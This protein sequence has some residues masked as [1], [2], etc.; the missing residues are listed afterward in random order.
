MAPSAGIIVGFD[1]KTV[2]LNA[3]LLA[4]IALYSVIVD[5]YVWQVSRIG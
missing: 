3:N 4:N 5:V 2:R 1:S